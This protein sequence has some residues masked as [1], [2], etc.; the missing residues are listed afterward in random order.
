MDS[1]SEEWQ[2]G[3]NRTYVTGENESNVN[4]TKVSDMILVDMVLAL[5]KIDGT[6]M[7]PTG[8]RL[9]VRKIGSCG[10]LFW[11]PFAKGH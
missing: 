10:A 1:V 2:K 4:K 3:R 7:V 8:H 9:M 5:R 6:K 11:C